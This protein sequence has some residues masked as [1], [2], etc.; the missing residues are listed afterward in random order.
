[1]APEIIHKESYD[2]SIDMWSL[3]CVAYELDTGKP[4]FYHEDRDHTMKKIIEVDYDLY[5]VRDSGL[6]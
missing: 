1:M 5:Q 6:R 2:Q 3:G 4:P